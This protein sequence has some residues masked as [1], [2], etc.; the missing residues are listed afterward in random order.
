MDIADFCECDQ[1][2]PV[3]RPGLLVSRAVWIGGL[4][5]LIA[6]AVVILFV[7]R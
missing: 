3:E 1:C 6:W 4:L 2:K 5:S 7:L